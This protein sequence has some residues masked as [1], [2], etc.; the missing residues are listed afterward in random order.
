MPKADLRDSNVS[1]IDFEDVNFRGANLSGADARN[2]I[3]EDSDLSGANL[4]GA[5]LRSVFI[6]GGDLRGA[7]LTGVKYDDFVLQQITGAVSRGQL[8][9]DRATISDDMKA[10]LEGMK[11]KC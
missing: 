9:L 8:N 10:K 4:S 1:G 6:E 11:R 5:D 3:L 2:A 7:N